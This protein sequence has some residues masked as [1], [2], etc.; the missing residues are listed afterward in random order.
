[1]SQYD[2]HMDYDAV[3]GFATGLKSVASGILDAVAS[4]PLV[5]TDGKDVGTANSSDQFYWFRE[6]LRFL[7]TRFYSVGAAA[8]TSVRL[9]QERDAGTAFDFNARV[10]PAEPNQFR[11]ALRAGLPEAFQ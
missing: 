6:Q 4:A 1:M 8:S 3:E 10:Q 2:Y 7:S 5:S 11:Q 9:A